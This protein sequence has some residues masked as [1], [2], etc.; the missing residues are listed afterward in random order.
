M[1][2][3]VAAHACSATSRQHHQLPSRAEGAEVSTVS[4]VSW[5]REMTLGKITRL[6]ACVSSTEVYLLQ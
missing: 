5:A 4:P 2:A 3:D 1:V 6:A